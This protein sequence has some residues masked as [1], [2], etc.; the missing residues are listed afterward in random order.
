MIDKIKKKKYNF[1]F[2]TFSKKIYVHYRYIHL[3]N[4]NYRFYNIKMA[5]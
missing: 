4:D 5:R 1:S 3:R 2:I